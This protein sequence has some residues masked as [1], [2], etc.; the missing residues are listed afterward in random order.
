M[1]YL[2][3]PTA[4]VVTGGTELLPFKIAVANSIVAN[5]AEA[6]IE[7]RVRSATV[8]RSIFVSAISIAR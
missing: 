8:T 1:N 6:W 2:A 5:C 3:L 4:V 7:K